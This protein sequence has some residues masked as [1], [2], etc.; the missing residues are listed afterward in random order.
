[1]EGKNSS[2]QSG[3]SFNEGQ[4]V[5]ADSEAHV[6]DNEQQREECEMKMPAL[7]NIPLPGVQPNQPQSA[8]LDSADDGD[9]FIMSPPQSESTDR[10]AES[11][12]TRRAREAS[13]DSP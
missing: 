11:T 1:M 6:F 5:M 8:E 13:T 10:M 7:E 4:E 12:E 9:V 2:Q 3:L